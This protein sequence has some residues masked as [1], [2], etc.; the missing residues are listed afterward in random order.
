MALPT[1]TGATT[2]K[3][4]YSIGTRPIAQYTSA[5]E[6]LLPDALGSVRQIVDGASSVTLAKSYEPYGSVLTSTGTASSIFGYAGEQIDTTGLIYLRARYM[7]PTLGMFLSRDPW[8]GDQLRPGSMNGWNYTEGNPVN[9]VD[10][11]GK[12]GDLVYCPPPNHWEEDPV[13]GYLRCVGPNVEE[14]PP[15]PPVG[16]VLNPPIGQ[17]TINIGSGVGQA[18]LVSLLTLACAAVLD[19]LS[20]PKPQVIVELGAGSYRNAIKM[21]SMFPSAIV[22]ATN[23]K[24]E[25]VLGRRYVLSGHT[26]RNSSEEFFM[27]MYR[28]W[29][30]A[31]TQGVIVGDLQSIE[32]SEVPPRIADIVYSILPYPSTAFDFGVAAALIAKDIP[33]TLAFVTAGTSQPLS[34]FRFGFEWFQPNTRFALQ[35][36]TLFGLEADLNWEGGPIATLAGITMP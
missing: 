31:K 8:E 25:W 10:P 23:R 5:W 18:A 6:Y 7:Q 3:Y 11:N 9:R 17:P 30:A 26:P 12:Q 16:S 13:D 29:A 15:L 34:D 33:G 28:G 22:I 27:D 4:L 14:Q 21:K 20:R 32:N 1:K 35:P 24:D 2:T 36:G 19:D